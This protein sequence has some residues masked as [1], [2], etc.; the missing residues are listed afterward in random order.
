M[1][2]TKSSTR[3]ETRFLSAR[4][5]S[6][7][8]T[9]AALILW[10]FSITQAKLEIGKF[11]LIHGFPIIFFFALGLLTIASAVLWPSKENHGKLL[12]MQLC[13]LVVSLWLAHLIVGGAQ[14]LFAV[15]YNDLGWA[16]FLVREGFT[17]SAV[18]WQ[19]NWPG[20]YILQSA[21]LQVSGTNTEDFA[22]FLPWL[23]IIW[24]LLFFF[25]VFIFFKNTIGKTHPNYCWAAMWIFYLGNWVGVQ[26]NGAQPFGVLCVFSILALLS[27]S[28]VWRQNTTT[29][30][31]R[32]SIIIIFAASTIVHLLGSL[33]ALAI[34]VG[35]Y[36]SRRMTSPKVLIIAA[37]FIAAWSMYGAG[38]Y[39]DHKLSDF[40]EQSFRMD[41]AFQQGIVNPVSGNESHAA[42]SKVRIIHSGLILAL[43]ILGGLLS[44]RLKR[45]R[46]TDI[47]V[48][49]ITTACALTAVAIA[50]G[51]SHELFNR[52]FL[53]LLPCIA[54]FGVKLLHSR[55]TAIVLGILLVITLPLAFI[56]QHGNQTMDYLSTS[57]ISG[58]R[59]FHERTIEGWVDGDNPLG[60]MQNREKYNLPEPYEELEWEDNTFTY[61]KGA[62]DNLPHYICISAHDRAVDDFFRNEPIRLKD[63]EEAFQTTT[64]VNLAFAN[65]QF[66][67]YVHE[68]RP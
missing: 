24:Q 57:Y 14:P 55:A 15:A 48:L 22:G 34:S 54:Y 17:N 31:H 61:A 40:I 64:N 28:A 56:S 29:L 1:S 21:A 47:F 39:F 66:S 53:F 60:R 50:I 20:N 16:D 65:P 42:V 26:N 9:I 12:L 6:I 37:L 35:I 49:A 11:G 59:F 5:I 25:P 3:Q 19:H 13:F 38:T 58:A 52:F 62:Y 8:L 4:Q 45:E 10:S 23:P 67:L 63:I 43:G 7:L 27:N 51:Y 18:L 2:I 41:E 33:V 36:V 30:G 32:F 46:Y 44:F 68:A